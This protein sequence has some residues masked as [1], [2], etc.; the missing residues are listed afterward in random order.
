MAVALVAERKLY[1]D[2]CAAKG[3]GHGLGPPT[4]FLAKKFLEI[5]STTM[6]QA[7]KATEGGE[8]LHAAALKHG[9][10]EAE[11]LD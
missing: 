8:L 3:R 6:T 7:Q 5:V 9:E 10:M 11:E 4:P 1:G 2:A